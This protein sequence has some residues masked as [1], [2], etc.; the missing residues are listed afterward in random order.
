MQTG[1]KLKKEGTFKL[2]FES[3]QKSNKNL[4][5]VFGYAFGSSDV[6]TTEDDYE[7]DF[8][9]RQKINEFIE[10]LEKEH[11]RNRIILIV[12]YLSRVLFFSFR[13]E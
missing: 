8:K 12:L 11:K 5:V 10:K 3:K 13:L 7:I 2:F 6:E 9:V 1:L 4:A